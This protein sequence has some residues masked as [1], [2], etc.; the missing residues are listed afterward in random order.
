MCS[1][2]GEMPGSLLKPRQCVN[3]STGCS[4]QFPSANLANAVSPLASWTSY[5]PSRA[6]EYW[7][8][9]NQS[10]VSICICASDFGMANCSMSAARITRCLNCT[11]CDR[12]GAAFGQ[13]VG[14]REVVSWI[15]SV[16]SRRCTVANSG[17]CHIGAA[18][19]MHDSRL[20]KAMTESVPLSGS[21]LAAK[22]LRSGVVSLHPSKRV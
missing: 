4:V 14:N 12:V 19:R 13:M 11:A 20:E 5:Q 22:W 1:V 3:T 7:A 2:S 9:G 6:G 16:V 21:G 17:E 15:V 18:P 8:W 10:V